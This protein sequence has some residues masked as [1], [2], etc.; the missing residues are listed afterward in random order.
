MI[1]FVNKRVDIANCTITAVTPAATASSASIA[2]S[3]AASVVA[4]AKSS[5]SRIL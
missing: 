1:D 4:S 5:G 3:P 2:S